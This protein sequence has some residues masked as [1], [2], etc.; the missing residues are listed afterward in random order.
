VAAHL[1]ATP[2]AIRAAAAVHTAA[3]AGVR[4]G[5]EAMQLAVALA[6]LELSELFGLG[7][8]DHSRPQTQAIFD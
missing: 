2:A 5:T 6:D 4:D 1:A 8:L 3:A 7:A